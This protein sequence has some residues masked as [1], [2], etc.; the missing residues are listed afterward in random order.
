MPGVDPPRL[1][2]VERSHDDLVRT[3]RDVGGHGRR[4]PAHTALRVDDDGAGTLHVYAGF[5]S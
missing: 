1:D 4:C 5:L 3:V 2:A